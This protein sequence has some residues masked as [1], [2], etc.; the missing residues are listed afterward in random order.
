MELRELLT[1]LGR[2]LW[3]LLIIPIAA[4]L[5]V[6]GLNAPSGT[7]YTSA[8]DLR[9]TNPVGD[10]T[11]ASVNLVAGSLV[12]AATSNEVI[13]KVAQAAGV[14]EK[15]VSQGL[16]ASRIADTELVHVTY[17][18]SKR[19]V[20]EKVM[21]AIPTA[22]QEQAFAPALRQAQRAEEEAQKTFDSALSEL[23]K[24]QEST[25]LSNPDREY[26]TAASEAASLKVALATAKGRGDTSSTKPI[27]DALKDA[28]DRLD[29]ITKAQA[30]F[31]APQYAVDNARDSLADRVSAV[32]DIKAR[33]SATIAESI[34]SEVTQ[35]PWRTG[36][37]RRAI[38]A[39][40]IGLALAI[41]ILAI[42]EL[43]RRSRQG[44]RDELY[45]REAAPA[46][47]TTHSAPVTPA[48]HATSVT[49]T[50]P[51]AG[52]HAVGNRDLGRDELR[53]RES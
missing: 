8:V 12:N 52:S 22:V 3:L 33:Q 4:L 17:W 13:T 14:D 37:L 50:T 20:V 43:L 7:K 41:L 18:A 21:S 28:Q 51:V 2:R 42:P 40:L 15:T 5:L 36:I 35:L 38:S 34:N 53:S 9:A 45:S 1:R 19:D 39:A 27:E 47:T 44:S 6:L 29:E 23:E 26:Q 31:T 10:P 30:E 25:G 11:V 48:T 46:V 24:V 49:G 32:G 16:S